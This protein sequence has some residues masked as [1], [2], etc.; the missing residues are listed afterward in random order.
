M[1]ASPRH[2]AVERKHNVLEWDTKKFNEEVD[3]S[4]GP[5]RRAR[6]GR[7]VA[8]ALRASQQDPI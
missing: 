4:G 5:R 2:W 6:R 1:I 8:L 3:V 7:R